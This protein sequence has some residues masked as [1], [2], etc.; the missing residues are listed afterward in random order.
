[1]PGKMR[2]IFEALVWGE[3]VDEGDSMP[4]YCTLGGVAKTNAFDRPYLAVN[5]YVSAELGRRLGLPAVPGVIVAN[6]EL[7]GFVSLR[8]GP[9]GERPPPA[10]PNLLAAQQPEL[11]AG[12]VMFDCWIGNEDRHTENFAYSVTTKRAHIFDHDRA[13]LGTTGTARLRDRADDHCL[14]RHPLAMALTDGSKLMSWAAQIQETHPGA[15][16]LAID[17]L[18]A[19]EMLNAKDALALADFLLHRRQQIL[20][21]LR[22]AQ[23]AGCFPGIVQG[24]LT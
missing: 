5:E 11:A 6:P 22:A 7:A 1:L 13:L 19:E 12:I 21:L 14:S 4:R 2:A 24:F 16:K 3:W 10:I 15:V 18:V 17:E 23:A 20:E 8:F 9:K